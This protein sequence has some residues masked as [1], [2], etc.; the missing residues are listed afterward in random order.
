MQNAATRSP[1]RTAAPSGALRT[2]PA[3]SLPGT[4][5]SSG[6]IWYAPRVCSTSGK[7][8]PAARTSITTPSPPGSGMSTSLSADSGPLSSTIWIARIRRRL[9]ASIRRLAGDAA[10]ARVHLLDLR[11]ELCLAVG[12]QRPEHVDPLV[13][14]GRQVVV[15]GLEARAVELDVERDREAQRDVAR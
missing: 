2:T 4:N 15:L 12:G 10:A 14:V 7:E 6:L 11:R 8:T 9:R 13:R 3:T 1:A 5:G